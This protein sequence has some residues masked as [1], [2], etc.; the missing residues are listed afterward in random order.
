MVLG[1]LITEDHG[2][3]D[4]LSD[5]HGYYYKQHLDLGVLTLFEVIFV[6]CRIV[7]LQGRAMGVTVMTHLDHKVI[8]L[9][10]ESL[11]VEFDVTRR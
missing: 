3:G 7:P 2:T 1:N 5:R 6:P 4:A 8:V 11:R 9:D 10:R